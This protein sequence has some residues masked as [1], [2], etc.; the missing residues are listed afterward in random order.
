MC[1]NGNFI[2]LKSEANSKR[3]SV[4]AGGKSMPHFL[5]DSVTFQVPVLPHRETSLVDAFIKIARDTCH[6][7]RKSSSTL[8]VEHHVGRIFGE[9]SFSA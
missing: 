5:G 2:K 1:H 3:L 4:G 6:E 8:I 7:S 9:C